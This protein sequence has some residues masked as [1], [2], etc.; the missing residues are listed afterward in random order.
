MNEKEYRLDSLVKKING[1][2][3]DKAER[4]VA[5]FEHGNAEDFV[6]EFQLDTVSNY[7][8]NRWFHGYAV[9]VETPKRVTLNIL[10]INSVTNSVFW[11]Q[12]RLCMIYEKSYDEEVIFNWKV[13]W[14][15]EDETLRITETTMELKQPDWKKNIKEIDL[16]QIKINLEQI[17]D[18]TVSNVINWAEVTE[19]Q[20]DLDGKCIPASVFSRA[21]AKSVRYR[22]T[23]PQIDSAAI[24]ADMMSLRMA[25]FAYEMKAFDVIGMLE[26]INSY[27]QKY[28]KTKTYDEFKEEG[29]SEYSPKELSLLPLY[30]IDETLDESKSK[31]ITEVSCVNLASFYVGLLRLGGV[32][33][34]RVF[35]V[36]QPFHYLTVLEHEDQYFTISSNEVYPMTP[37]RLYGDT[38]VVRI[39]SPS[40]YIDKNGEATVSEE[41]YHNIERTFHKGIP[42]F[43]LPKYEKDCCQW[44]NDMKELLQ[45][46]N[47]TSPEAYHQGIV[48]FVKEKDR[49][50][51][52]SVYTWALYAYQ[53]LLVMKPQAYLIWSIHSQDAVKFSKKIQSIDML[54]KWMKENLDEGSIFEEKERIMTADQVLRNK[55]GCAKDKGVLFYTIIKLLYP[56]KAGGVL[57]TERSECYV[58][59]EENGEC[60]AYDMVTGK[61]KELKNTYIRLFFNDK[62]VRYNFIY[63]QEKNKEW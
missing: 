10:D 46:Q 59:V 15:S 37:E 38:E 63:G 26:M 29:I 60:Y 27:A 13:I 57:L 48:E 6:K 54:L 45:M 24:L 34:S 17:K 2:L 53:T 14:K 43:T 28:F 52:N 3:S 42:I 11:C 9:N 47:Y 1:I 12:T 61:T 50:Y 25:R 5:A 40:Y 36:I 19:R 51:P 49:A 56:E 4:L 58:E 32:D 62:K 7:Y 41:E 23:H 33:P 18:K 16:A 8:M 20:A 21:I 39:V 55:K 22:N 31:D 30:S 35:V 44:P